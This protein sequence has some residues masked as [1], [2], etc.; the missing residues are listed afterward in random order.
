MDRALA[1]EL[2]H[3]ALGD[4]ESLPSAETVSQLLAEA[5]L[6][7][8]LRKPDVPESLVAIGWYL[9]AVGSS[10]YAL[11]AYGVDR[12]RKAFQVSGHIFDLLLQMPESNVVDR[13]K[14]C[15]ACQIAYLRGQLNPNATAIYQRAFSGKLIDLGLLENFQ[16]VALSCG[17]ALLGL[18]IRWVFRVTTE[19]QNEAAGLVSRWGFE[20][21]SS[22]PFGSAADVA[23]GVRHLA[24][25]LV[26]GR[27]EALA[28][29]RSVFT[30]A[31]STEAYLEDQ[32]SRWV[33][34][35]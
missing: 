32:V 9:H 5:E 29:A 26:Y 27:L 14:Y 24:S 3:L 13:L 11:R 12:Q 33:A 35:H 23:E 20:N 18:D 7:L 15:F 21:I 1:P 8:L 6:A 4:H 10:K 17:V 16:E 22:T 34:A 30:R 19:L 31:I 28:R 25:F 2:I